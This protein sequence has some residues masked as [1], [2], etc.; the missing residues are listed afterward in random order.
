M[1]AVAVVVEA[2]V[3]VADM[4][5][6]MALVATGTGAASTVVRKAISRATVRSP[7]RNVVV[8]ATTAAKRATDRR[9]AHPE[10]PALAAAADTVTHRASSAVRRDT[11]HGTVT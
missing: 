5:V 9:T 3:A 2:V 7:V 1:A 6:E 4:T 8:A 10:T 11:C